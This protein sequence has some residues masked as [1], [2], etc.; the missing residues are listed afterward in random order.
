RR[1][2]RFADAV[3]QPRRREGPVHDRARSAGT[4]GG[5][6]VAAPAAVPGKDDP[7]DGVGGQAGERRPA[8]REEEM[9]RSIPIC[10]SL[11][12][13]IVAAGCASAPAAGSSAA[14][15]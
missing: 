7:R 8:A 10:A 9:K 5:E 13:P 14:D 6:D 12:L 11:L 15:V 1:D 2:L 4:M 3:H